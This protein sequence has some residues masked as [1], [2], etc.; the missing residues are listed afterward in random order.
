M[1]I[2]CAAICRHYGGEGEV[3][4]EGRDSREG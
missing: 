2:F 4:G 1:K 3:R